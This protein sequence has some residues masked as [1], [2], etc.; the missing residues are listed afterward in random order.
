[1]RPE[2]WVLILLMLTPVLW[3]AHDLWAG[4]AEQKHWLAPSDDIDLIL[5]DES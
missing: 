2:H 5:D 4:W 3:I 1:M